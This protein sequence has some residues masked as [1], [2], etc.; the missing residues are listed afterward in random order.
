MKFN[1]RKED[2]KNKKLR[3][4]L[5]VLRARLPIFNSDWEGVLEI[6]DTGTSYGEC[7]VL[8]IY[9]HND[10][11]GVMSNDGTPEAI[12]EE[13][14]FVPWKTPVKQSDEFVAGWLMCK[15][16]EFLEEEG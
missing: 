1:I 6:E 4:V 11:S 9:D 16:W 7:I 13:G 2:R 3:G 5:K 8:K 15:L 14:F 12:N 10:P